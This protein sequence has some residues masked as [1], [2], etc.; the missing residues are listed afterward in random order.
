MKILT[1][2][3][4]HG[5]KDAGAVNPITGLREKSV[6]LGLKKRLEVR[7][8]RVGIKLHFTRADDYFV[9][10]PERA[11]DANENKSDLFFSLHC[12][13][14][15]STVTGIETFYYRYSKRSKAAAEVCHEKLM[16]R[17]SRHNDR[18][19][20][21]ANFHVLRETNM[22]AVLW[23]LEF[24]DTV[25]GDMTLTDNAKL[26][27]YA[28]AIIDSAYDL[29]MSRDYYKVDGPNRLRRAVGR[30]CACVCGK[31]TSNSGAH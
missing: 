30:V 15:N 22:R 17:F 27:L 23:E 28:D 29:L 8:K 12:N 1:I 11:R 4:G 18:G 24:I 25:L 6:V 21:G 19:V 7:A 3:F 26:D 10:L 13:A 5:G 31:L 20:K 9:E 16:A 2:D 14:Y